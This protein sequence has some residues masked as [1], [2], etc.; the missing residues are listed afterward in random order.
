MFV[1]FFLFIDDF[2]GFV[3]FLLCLVSFLLVSFRF[4]SVSFLVLQSPES[5]CNSPLQNRHRMETEAPP[6]RHRSRGVVRGV[7]C[8]KSYHKRII[9]ICN[10]VIRLQV[11]RMHYHLDM[12]GSRPARFINGLDE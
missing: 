5:W 12:M 10:F 7:I 6:H 4:V 3:S 1:S 8:I 9:D 2:F 11:R